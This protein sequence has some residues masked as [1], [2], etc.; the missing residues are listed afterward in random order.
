MRL[1]NPGGVQ[2]AIFTV[3]QVQGELGNASVH[4]RDPAGRKDSFLTW[5]DSWATPQLGN[6]FPD[7]EG[8][9]AEIRESYYRVVALPT[10]PDRQANGLLNREFR[11]WDARLGRLL[12]EL[13]DVADFVERVG[14]L[15]VPDTSALMEGGMFTEFAWHSLDESLLGVP[16]RLVVPALVVEELDEL[17]RRPGERQ[18]AQARKVLSAL[19]DLHSAAPGRPAP[20]SASQDVTIEVLLD[21]GWHQRMPSNDTEII[22]QAV[23]MRELT[24]QAVILAACDYSQLYRAAQVGLRAVLMPRPT[25]D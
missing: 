24:G 2:K 11:E 1:K 9:F 18:R 14:S 12:S 19:W 25:A 5:C 17:K 15:V 4:G 8:I 20:L 10:S 13:A 16:V 3:K 7:R 6:H 23:R 22:D 21:D